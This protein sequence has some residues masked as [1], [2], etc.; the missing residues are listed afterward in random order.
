MFMNALVG[1][2]LELAWL[3]ILKMRLSRN[4]HIYPAE[5]SL[6]PQARC[7]YANLAST[8]RMHASGR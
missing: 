7:G 2:L 1:S 5:R 8:L 4:A 3:P 6:L